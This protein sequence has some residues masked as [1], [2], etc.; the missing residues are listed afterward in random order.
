MRHFFTSITALLL[1]ATAGRA[2]VGITTAPDFV[3]TDIHG[4][5]HNLY[6]LLD[7]G[8]YVMIDLYAYWCGPCCQTAPEIRKVY[9]NYGC[10][11][12]ELF[13]IGLEADG[14]IQQCETFEENC[15]SAGGYPVASGLQGGGSPAVDAFAPLAFPTIILVAPDR[16]IIQ[17]DIWPFSSAIA[18]NILAPLGLQKME[19]TVSGTQAL[20]PEFFGD[21]RLTPNPFDGRL[22]VGFEMEEAAPVEIALTNTLGQVVLRQQQGVLPAG[23]QQLWVETAGLPK[24]LYFVQLKAGG[25]YSRALR[26]TKG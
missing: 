19:C 25:K 2:Q 7:E 3:V 21:A 17:Q 9:E 10:N 4:E 23:R 6:Q 13:V 11:S 16:A 18:D 8:K 20:A 5:Q 1:L 14:T 26:A 15:G 24:G 22:S 12:G